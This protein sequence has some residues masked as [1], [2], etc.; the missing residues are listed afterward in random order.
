MVDHRRFGAMSSAR[1]KRSGGRG[2]RRQ[3]GAAAKQQE[4]KGNGQAA[5]HA[6][7]LAPRGPARNGPEALRQMPLAVPPARE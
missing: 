1:A 4:H 7:T 3:H 6:V 2:G 5:A